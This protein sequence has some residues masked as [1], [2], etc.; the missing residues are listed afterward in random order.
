MPSRNQD[1]E[2]KN[3]ES[4]LTNLPLFQQIPQ[5][6][7]HNLIPHISY[8]RMD[9]GKILFH[10][11][12]AASC[13]YYVFTGKVKLAVNSLTGGEKVVEIVH[14]G[15]SFG[16]AV[17]FIEE[18]YPV[19]AEIIEQAELIKIPA[20]PL[21]QALR[22]D[23]GLALNMLAS[24]SRRLHFLVRELENTCLHSAI[25]RVVAFLLTEAAR[26]NL[27]TDYCNLRLPANRKII[28]SHLNLTPETLSRVFRQLTKDNIIMI[29][30]R[31]VQILNFEKLKQFHQCSY[32]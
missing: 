6:I 8:I 26:E 12:E 30:G 15:M 21:L 24:L 2:T 17:V 31:N 18:P 14:P 32:F 19:Y 4:L 9:A 27:S 25:Q 5:N 29:H 23:H 1:L 7:L 13:F 20:A 3:L 11:G 22:T 28:A 16:E 10:Q